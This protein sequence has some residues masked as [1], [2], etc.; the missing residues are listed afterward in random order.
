MGTGVTLRLRN[1]L[2]CAG[3]NAE[4]LDKT[5][6]LLYDAEVVEVKD[7]RDY[8]KL[9]GLG[10]LG[11]KP[12][13]LAR[14]SAALDG[15]DADAEQQQYQQPPQQQQQ[16][17]QQRPQQQQPQQQQPQQQRQQQQQQQQQQLA[18][19]L[20]QRLW[21]GHEVRRVVAA[22]DP[23]YLLFGKFSPRELVR[24]AR[25]ETEAALA[26]QLRKLQALPLSAPQ[27][28]LLVGLQAVVRGF[29]ERR[30]RALEAERAVWRA[31]AAIDWQD[32]VEDIRALPGHIGA[33]IRATL[34]GTAGAPSHK[35]A[36]KTAQR[37]RK[38][39]K[40]KE[41]AAAA[42]AAASSHGRVVAD[43]TSEAK[44]TLDASSGTPSALRP[45]D[46]ATTA[47]AAAAAAASSH[48][49]VVANGTSEA[50]ST[51][52]ASSGNPIGPAAW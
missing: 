11:I 31:R 25:L 2:T 12:L 28:A 1:F 15:L 43:G 34:D 4:F 16:P 19:V 51:F 32:G 48:G 26:T 22:H 41:A 27:L 39:A 50:K 18:S 13:S 46:E 20:I 14:I 5:L 47:T 10:G 49:R 6:E 21:R 3:I 45:E 29:L 37:E 30:R 35:S 8:R 33:G 40:K 9:L 52:D 36:K 38:K 23:T 42:A 17:Q 44:S 24:R 7:L